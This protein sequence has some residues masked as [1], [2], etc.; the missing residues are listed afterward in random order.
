MDSSAAYT[1]NMAI[2][3]VE[4][5]RM[6][7]GKYRQLP[8]VDKVISEQS[9]RKYLKLFKQ[10][11]VVEIVRRNIDD[12]RS[13]I[14]RGK[15][16]PSLKEI[17]NNIALHL[18]LLNNPG[19]KPVINATGIIIH[20]N[21]GRAPLSKDTIKAMEIASVGFNNLEF[22][23]ESGVRG[24]RHVHIEN[25][26]CRLSGA[27]SGMT[28]NNNAAAVL[29]ALTALAKRKE[30]IVSRGEAVEIGGGFR[31]PDVMRQSGAKLVEVG[32]TNCTYI[33]D[34]ENAINERTIAL[35]RVHPSNFRLQGFTHRIEMD[36]MVSLAHE[37]DIMIIDDLGSGCFLDTGQFGLEPEPT[38]QESVK[39]GIDVITFSGDKL[40]GGPQAGIILGKK[41]YVDI[42][43]KHPLA[44]A[45]RIDKT[46]LAGLAATLT[47][48]LRG[49][50]L[51]KIPVWNMISI[52]I[53]TVSRR[54]GK[55]ADTLPG[56]ARVVDGVS[57]VGGGSLPGGT[58]PTKLLEI[59]TVSQ[60][61]EKDKANLI[62]QILRK[63][64]PPIIAR[65]EKD[66]VYLDPRTVLPDEDKTII[67]A[68]QKL[69][70]IKSY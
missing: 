5:E 34:Y 58:I 61:K 17:I 10:E 28:V 43:K 6:N 7:E 21:L 36:E 1:R 44:R 47:H 63:N 46:R 49:E 39:A 55:W 57:M 48:Y 27:E 60:K 9:V 51:E 65:I 3:V 12:A 25:I 13:H 40:V 66:T 35:L 15:N 67:K 31:I 41:K 52:P 22:D 11:V 18:D 29:L 4:C 16:P 50:A 30:V 45:L 64:K 24:S 2:N 19:L 54:A 62:S 56:V 38:V 68:L 14:Q 53:E 37:K 33:A 70:D 23:L 59:K 20:T 42:I 69:I 26:L 8:S 32:T